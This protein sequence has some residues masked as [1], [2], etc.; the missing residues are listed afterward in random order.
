[1]AKTV[2]NPFREPFSPSNRLHP[3]NPGG[4]GFSALSAVA[5]H[6]LQRFNYDL[7]ALI[8]CLADIERSSRASLSQNKKSF[9]PGG[10]SHTCL[11]CSRPFTPSPKALQNS[12]LFGRPVNNCYICRKP[13]PLSPGLQMPRSY[14]PRGGGDAELSPATT[15]AGEGPIAADKTS[16]VVGGATAAPP[17]ATPAPEAPAPKSRGGE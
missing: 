2:L 16:E 17:S 3:I 11:R 6:C 9:H 4:V 14:A 8:S 13:D 15:T 5:A 10:H 7:A 12:A 1:M